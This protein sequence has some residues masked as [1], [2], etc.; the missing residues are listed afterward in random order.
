MNTT[1]SLVGCVHVSVYVCGV[2]IIYIIVVKSGS[3]YVLE[4]FNS[5]GDKYS[6]CVEINCVA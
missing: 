5:L 4:R 2:D 3:L 6:I 1:V